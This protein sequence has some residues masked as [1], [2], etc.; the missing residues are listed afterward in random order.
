[1]N[2]AQIIESL[3]FESQVV[4]CYWS[5]LGLREF[6]YQKQFPIT[7]DVHAK[8]NANIILNNLTSHLLCDGNT[9][10]ALKSEAD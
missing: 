5:R 8:L 6:V 7:I 4:E 9:I 10:N 3:V 2:H 1:M